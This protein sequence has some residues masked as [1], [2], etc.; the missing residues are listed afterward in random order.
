[1]KNAIETLKSFFSVY[2][3]ILTWKAHLGI[4]AT[5]GAGHQGLII[6][7]VLLLGSK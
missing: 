3:V 1:M 7:G 4:A 6:L 5:V 2:N